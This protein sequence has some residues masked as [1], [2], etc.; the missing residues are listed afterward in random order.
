MNTTQ[1]LR[2]RS[3]NPRRNLPASIGRKRKE[4]NFLG[5]FMRSLV[6][7]IATPCAYGRY[8]AMP[9]C[10]V[11]DFIICQLPID[12]TK[13]F[14]YDCISLTAIEVKISDWRRG[15]QQAYR[16]KY[17]A[18]LSVVV[19][20]FENAAKALKSVN[21]F[22]LLGIGLWTYDSAKGIIQKHFSPLEHGALNQTKRRQALNRIHSRIADLNLCQ[23]HE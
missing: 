14:D 15:I 6:A 7:D 8:F 23:S 1:E 10:G 20:P 13:N 12:I 9:G 16:Y 19:V 4:S 5:S 17:Y 2:F 11:A 22:D 3:F 21:C 18:D